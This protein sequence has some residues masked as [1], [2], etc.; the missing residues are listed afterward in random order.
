MSELIEL[1]VPPD[2]QTNGGHEVLRAFVVEGALS[3]SMQRAFDEPAVWG[4]FLSDVARY[5]AQVY[6]REAGIDAT[7][8]LA[9]IYRSFNAHDM[10]N[11]SDVIN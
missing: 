5:V 7:E 2:A 10:M 9:D 11:E 3:I 1:S 6:A 4:I 8:A